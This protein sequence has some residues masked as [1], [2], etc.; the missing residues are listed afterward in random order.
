MVQCLSWSVLMLGLCRKTQTIWSK[1]VFYQVMIILYLRSIDLDKWN[2][3]YI[4]FMKNGGNH[5]A[6]E[7]LNKIN[8]IIDGK[9]DYHSNY[10]Q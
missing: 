6:R 5:L 7:Y 9:V 10:I 2:I 4:T 8:A 3:K 1:Q